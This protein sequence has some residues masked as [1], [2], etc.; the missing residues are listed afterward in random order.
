LVYHYIK[1]GN[2]TMNKYGFNTIGN[3]TM[4]MQNVTKCVCSHLIEKNALMLCV[5]FM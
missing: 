5:R 2:I 3:I 4:Y 1:I